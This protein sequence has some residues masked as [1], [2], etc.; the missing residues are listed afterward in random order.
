MCDGNKCLS[1]HFAILQHE[2]EAVSIRPK[3]VPSPPPPLSCSKVPTENFF[4]GKSEN[5]RANLRTKHEMISEMVLE[6]V[7]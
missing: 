4:S 1:T 7:L 2:N 3:P 6:N 5:Y